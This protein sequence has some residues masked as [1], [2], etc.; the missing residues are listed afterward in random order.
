MIANLSTDD[1]QK[2]GQGLIIRMHP[3]IVDR[4]LSLVGNA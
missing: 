3:L 4:F 2:L 1:N